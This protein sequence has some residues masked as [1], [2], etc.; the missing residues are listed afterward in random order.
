MEPI[1]ITGHGAHHEHWKRPL[2]RCRK[3]AFN[4]TWNRMPIDVCGNDSP[5]KVAGTVKDFD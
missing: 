1:W 5:V 4:E 2:K 3:P